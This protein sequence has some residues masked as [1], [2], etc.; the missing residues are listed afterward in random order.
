MDGSWRRRE[1]GFRSRASQPACTF[2]PAYSS[3][4]FDPA[5]RV[6][7]NSAQFES[8]PRPFIRRTGND[9]SVR[10]VGMH[11]RWHDRLQ[12]DLRDATGGAAG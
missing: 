1:G 10:H 5:A 3:R 2:A 6:K 11:A 7:A 8:T 12:A 4:P 9:C